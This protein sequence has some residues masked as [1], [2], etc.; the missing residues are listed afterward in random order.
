MPGGC[1]TGALI[2]NEFDDVYVQQ[3]VCNGC[4]YCVAAC[5]FGV[6][7]RSKA[8]GAVAQVYAVLRPPEGRHGAGLRQVVPDRLD[9]VR[10][11]LA[12]AGAC[13]A[14]RGR[15]AR[16]RARRAP[17]STAPTTPASTS[18]LN[19]FF[20]LTEEPAA[21]NLPPAPRRPSARDGP[22]LPVERGGR[23]RRSAP[24]ARSCW[25]AAREERLM[26]ARR[27]AGAS[28]RRQAGGRAAQSG[29]GALRR[30]ARARPRDAYR[31]VPILKQ[32]TWDHEIAAYFYLGGISSGA[33]VLGAL[34]E[35][36]GGGR[37]QDAGA[38]GALRGVRHAAALPAAADRRPGQAVALPP[39]AAHLQALVADEPGRLDADRA[40]RAWPR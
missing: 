7:G 13:R 40:R 15:A 37:A 28:G 32:P 21:Y 26:A 29:N 24:S 6:L 9:P 31:D 16:A 30:G 17:T 5:P 10:A 23:H 36:V 18:A 2:R 3:D 11:G 8:D 20:L 22:A 12:A 38:H 39:H 33:C 1:P 34:A 25:P 4:G 19:A 35:L 27:T 14:A